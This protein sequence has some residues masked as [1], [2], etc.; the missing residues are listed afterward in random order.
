MPQLAWELT[1]TA[2]H[3]S[4]AQVQSLPATHAAPS[5]SFALG[6]P[7]TQPTSKRHAKKS[8]RLSPRAAPHR[9]QPAAAACPPDAASCPPAS[10]DTKPKRI[11]CACPETRKPRDECTMM[12]GEEKCA[13]Q[14]EAHKACLR[15]EGF[16]V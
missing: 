8:G 13:A 4:Q 11:C 12:Y 3:M 6:Q 5:P 16:N 7:T 1:A 10:G 15:A 9:S 14:I 2:T